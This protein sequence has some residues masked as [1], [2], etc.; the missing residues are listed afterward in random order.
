MDPSRVNV[1]T[2]KARIGW[3]AIL[4]IAL[5]ATSLEAKLGLYHPEHSQEHL[6]S[7]AFKLSECRLERAV[8]DPPLVAFS[9]VIAAISL[10]DAS[11]EPEVLDC[12]PLRTH[13]AFHSRSHW[14][15]PPPVRS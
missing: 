15:R 1:G 7:K 5:L 6:V 14:F 9:A 8:A 11:S 12:A 10:D 13:P 3:I 4:A 2:K